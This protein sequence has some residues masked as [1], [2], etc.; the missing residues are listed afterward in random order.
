M[1]IVELPLDISA[2][3]F[4]V[5]HFSVFFIQGFRSVDRKMEDRRMPGGF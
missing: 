3:D 2:L 5:H 4:S 1:M